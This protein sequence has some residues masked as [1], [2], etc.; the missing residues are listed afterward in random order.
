MAENLETKSFGRIEVKDAERG[1]VTA[2]V[3]TLNIV[4]R[5]GDVILPGAVRGS[6]VKMSGYDHDTILDGAPPAGLGTINVRDNR[7]VLEGKFFLGTQRGRESFEVVK[8]M[9]DHGEW[10]IGF[11]NV[12]VGELTEEWKSAGARRVISSLD[13]IEV[14]PVFEGANQAT[15]TLTV[16]SADAEPEIN[17][18]IDTIEVSEAPAPEPD[19]AVAAAEAAALKEAEAKALALR[20]LWQDEWER[21]QR[22][23]RRLAR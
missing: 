20:A 10:S 16:K 11:R 21:F 6:I 8:E 14:S 12:K 18:K 23:Q 19:P 9:G 15:S 1:E 22:L 2:I 17:V 13:I 3:N 7:V 4:D 5:D